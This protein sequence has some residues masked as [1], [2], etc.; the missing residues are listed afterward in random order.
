MSDLFFIVSV[1]DETGTPEGH[2]Y[3]DLEAAER[4]MADLRFWGGE[5]LHICY[6]PVSRSLDPITLAREVLRAGDASWHL[7]LEAT[8]G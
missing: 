2:V 1:T 3:E 5:S 7:W 4:K 6:T 8:Q